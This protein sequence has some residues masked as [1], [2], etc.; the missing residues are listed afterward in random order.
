M[1]HFGIKLYILKVVRQNGDIPLLHC[2]FVDNL[3]VDNMADLFTE[4]LPIGACRVL[5]EKIEVTTRNNV[6]YL[7]HDCV[8]FFKS[9]I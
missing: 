8:Y 4:Q 6:N 9:N 1:R 7:L 5:R 2:K 3:A